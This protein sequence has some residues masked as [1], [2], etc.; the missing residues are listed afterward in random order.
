MFSENCKEIIELFIGDLDQN[1]YLGVWRYKSKSKWMEEVK[2][3]FADFRF[4]KFM[5]VFYVEPDFGRLAGMKENPTDT[6][7]S[8]YFH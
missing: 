2:Q 3:T 7:A 5:D 1:E 6:D 8:V 4:P